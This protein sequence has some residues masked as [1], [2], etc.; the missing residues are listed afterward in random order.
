MH[1]AS[2][3]H[4]PSHPSPVVAAA[5][6][7]GGGQRNDFENASKIVKAYERKVG[8]EINYSVMTSEEF[9]FRKR[10]NDSFII[11]VLSQSRSMLVGDEEKFY[12]II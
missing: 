5:G 8:K 2:R 6:R 9:L 3:T 4:N 1:T 7:Y 10:K 12:S 11:R